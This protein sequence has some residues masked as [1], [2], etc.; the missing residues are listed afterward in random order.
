MMVA[1]VAEVRATAKA[2]FCSSAASPRIV[3]AICL[4]ASPFAKESSPAAAW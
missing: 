4:V 1:F 2:S 3:T